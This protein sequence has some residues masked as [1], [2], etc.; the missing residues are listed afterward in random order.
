MK[1]SPALMRPIVISALLAVAVSQTLNAATQD[2]RKISLEEC[3]KIALEHNLD[4]Q[5]ERINPEISRYN[6]SLA[7][8]DWDPLFT[9][10][11]SHSFSSSPGGVDAQ[12]RPFV[13][14]ESETDSFNLG[15][16]GALPS[17]LTYNLTGNVADNTGTNPFG[18]FE[19]TRGSA[20]MTLR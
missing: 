20:L 8:A 7:Y 11:G 2:T 14:T 18:P 9:A 16:Q 10:G 15:L 13:G 6:I 1:Q 5:I 4:V 12:N 3:I 19:N 17:G